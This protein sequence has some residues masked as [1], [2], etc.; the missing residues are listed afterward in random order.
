MTKKITIYAFNNAT[1][2]GITG[3]MDMF[4]SAGTLWNYLQ[5]LAPKPYFD[6]TVASFD[7]KPVKCSNEL[8]IK[9]HRSIK[10][11]TKTDLIIIPGIMSNKVEETL[12]E[13]KKIF[14][15]LKKQHQKGTLIASV[16]TGAFILAEAGLLNGKQATTHWVHATNL[17]KKYPQIKVHAEKMITDE[18]TI[19]CAGGASAGCELS[20]YLIKKFCGRE[21]AL[22][23]SKSFLVDMQ[24]TSQVPYT[25]LTGKKEHGDEQIKKIQQ[26]IDDHYSEHFTLDKLAQK[27]G[28]SSRNFKRRFKQATGHTPIDYL[29]LS[30]LEAAKRFLETTKQGVEEIIF[31]IGYEDASSFRKLFKNRTG[32][33]PKDYRNKFQGMWI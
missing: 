24:R 25:V 12:K 17:Q 11:V 29:Q 28:M 18:G 6:I 9:P 14:G 15:W 30:R 7:G 3:P 10:S 26:W 19:L 31:K 21:V 22:E 23:C 2:S 4:R 27:F 8:M 33:S 5:G 32:L 1:S 16:C 13:Q 20:L